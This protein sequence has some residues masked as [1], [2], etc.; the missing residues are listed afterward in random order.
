MTEPLAVSFRLDSDNAA[1]VDFPSPS[2]MDTDSNCSSE[3]GMNI[4]ASHARHPEQRSSDNDCSGG[5]LRLVSDAQKNMIM[6]HAG[7]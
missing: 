5:G 1:G 6:K 7:I 4:D 2:R 3:D